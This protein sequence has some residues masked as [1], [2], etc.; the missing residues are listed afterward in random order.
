MLRHVCL[1]V[2]CVAL[3]MSLVD[4]ADPLSLEVLQKL[5]SAT[6]LINVSSGS[7]RSMGS[8]FLVEANNDVGYIVTNSHVCPKDLAVRAKSEITV[9]LNSGTKTERSLPAEIIAESAD[10]DLAVL[11]VTAKNLPKS[12]SVNQTVEVRETLPVFVVG[13]PFGKDLALNNSN[14]AVTISNATV[15]SLRRDRPDHVFLIQL[16]GNLNPGN[17]GGPVVDQK[18]QIIGVAVARIEN[19]GIGFA[20]PSD[21]LTSLLQGD[22]EDV[23]FESAPGDS[24]IKVQCHLLDPMGKIQKVTMLFTNKPGPG[25]RGFNQTTVLIRKGGLAE[26]MIRPPEIANGEI[27]GTVELVLKA[28]GAVKRLPFTIKLKNGKLED[29]LVRSALFAPNSAVEKVS[30]KTEVNARKAQMGED[31]IGMAP[32]PDGSGMFVLTKAGTAN[33]LNFWNIDS[34]Q[35]GPEIRVPR[36]PSHL[37]LQ[38]QQLIVTCPESNTVV[39]V[40]ST[41]KKVVGAVELNLEDNLLP[42][43]V[44]PGNSRDFAYVLCSPNGE[45]PQALTAVVEIDLKSNDFK[46]IIKGNIEFAAVSQDAL[47]TQDNFGGSPS[48]KPLVYSLAS[49]RNGEKKV[50]FAGEHASCGPYSVTAKGNFVATNDKGK[51]L[52]FSADRK[53]SLWTTDGV[54]ISRYPDDSAFLIT[55]GDKVTNTVEWPLKAVGQAGNTLWEQLIKVEIPINLWIT[56]DI[57][58]NNSPEFLIVGTMREGSSLNFASKNLPLGISQSYVLVGK[59]ANHVVFSTSGYSGQIKSKFAVRIKEEAKVWYYAKLPTPKVDANIPDQIAVGETLRLQPDVPVTANLYSVKSGPEGMTCDSNTA[60]IEW[61]AEIA[62]LGRYDV[63]IVTKENG[64]ETPVLKFS[65]RVKSKAK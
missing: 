43:R 38:G 51:T 61:T 10:A 53:E 20:I 22:V 50:I 24:T 58:F 57:P 7:D 27:N 52:C 16:D 32:S 11:K 59:E 23:V 65:L 3:N 37:L 49:L 42:C 26:A 34:N 4:A 39:F 21:T 18:G 30:G 1:F 17:S 45:K 48:G 14:P 41:T 19:S 2:V 44:C 47:V 62:N 5:Q 63:E 55:T 31:V 35:V 54:L 13:F 36:S 8:G 25:N 12:L 40:D 33:H 15:S 60:K 56:Q 6:V 64:K 9:V 46:S 29:K 28:G